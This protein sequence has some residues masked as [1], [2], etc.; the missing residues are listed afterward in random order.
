MHVLIVSGIWPPDVGGPASHAPEAAAYLHGRGHRVEVVTTA[1]RAPERKPYP[2]HWVSR[3]LPPGARHAAGVLAVTRHA[4]RADVVYST[5]MLGRT[6]AGALATRTPYV[7]KLTQDPAF[8]R[9]RWRGIVGGGADEFQH[10]GGL[11]VRLLRSAR[12]AEL[13]GAAH[14]LCPSAYLRGLVVSWGVPA[15]RVSVLP[16]PAP[17]PSHL[18]DRDELRRRLEF[19]GPT[20]AFAGRLT[21]A[22]AL[23]VALDALA[24]VDGVALVLAGNGEERAA[25]ERRVGELGLDGRVLFLGAQPRERVLELFHAADAAVLS[26]SWENFPHAAVEA[27]TVGTPVVATDV[28]GVREIVDDGT[29]GLVV[30]AGDVGAFA[31]AIRR[32]AGDASL[33]ER[34]RAGAAGSAERFAPEKLLPELEAVL[35]RAVR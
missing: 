30:P 15:E 9:A 2:V 14:V 1:E 6:A 34:L 11:R 22:K 16:N 26:S 8:E 25:L 19:D 23:D 18:P 13:R 12:D 17:R 33:R 4:R 32:V 35:E 3:S 28:G 24:Q 31:G 7:A 5:G 20:L 27:L 29:N 10:G 21:A